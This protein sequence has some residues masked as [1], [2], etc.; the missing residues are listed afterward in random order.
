MANK[1]KNAAT[2]STTHRPAVRIGSRVRGTD[3]GVAGRIVWANAVSVK[4]RWD[5]GEQVTW[6]RDSLAD[7]PIEI[8]DP[9]GD[10]QPPAAPADPAAAEPPATTGVPPA[11]AETAPP[12]PDAAAAPAAAA[13]DAG[14]AEPALPVPEPAEET[15]ATPSTQ[16]G[17]TPA[18][19]KRRKAPAAPKAKK[20][21]ALGAAARVLAEEGR[22]MTCREL[23]GAMAAKGYWTSPGG[24]TPAAT[25]CS[26]LLREIATKGGGSRFRKAERGQ[27]ARTAAA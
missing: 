22:P 9:D 24:R 25:L 4:V 10:E 13:T 7:R 23:I 6:K 1:K 15:T 17:Q 27:F 8:R 16:P 19:P 12:A 5:D 14:A 3:D 20:V 18:Q 21:S 26:A 11:A 2:P